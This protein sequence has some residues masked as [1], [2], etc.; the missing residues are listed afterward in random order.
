[1]PNQLVAQPQFLT[2]KDGDHLVKIIA[3]LPGDIDLQDRVAVLDAL[4]AWLMER[5]K[6]HLQ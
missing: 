4:I 3:P 5:R 2:T 6:E 1:M